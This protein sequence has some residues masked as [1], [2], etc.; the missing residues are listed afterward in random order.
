MCTT[1]VPLGSGIG[2]L[3]GGYLNKLGPKCAQII[4]DIIS[5]IGTLIVVLSI[6]QVSVSMMIVGRII[7]GLMVGFNASIVTVYL[8][9]ISPSCMSGRIGSIYQGFGNIGIL[10]ASCMGMLLGDPD[11][12]DN[13][14]YLYFMFGLPVVTSTLRTLGL[15]T[16]F[17]FET[18]KY[19]ISKAKYR[20]ARRILGKIYKK[21]HVEDYYYTIMQG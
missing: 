21:E 19:L 10:V 14:K 12:D 17:N 18:P 13:M 2:A 5:I 9:Q 11:M 1:L 8:N 15:L 16:C 7:T 20:E 6:Q 4:T 3:F